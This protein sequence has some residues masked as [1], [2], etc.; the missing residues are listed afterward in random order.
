MTTYFASLQENH[1]GYAAIFTCIGVGFLSLRRIAKES[2][3][4]GYW[5]ASFFLNALGFLFWSGAVPMGRAA[6]YLLGELFHVAGFIFLVTG[7]YRFVGNEYRKWNVLAL[8]LW[9]AA[10]AASILA[11]RTHVDVAI[12]S[13]KALRAVIFISAGTM[14]LFQGDKKMT[15][16]RK[17]AGICLMLWGIY[18]LIFAFFWV[19][20]YLYFGFLVGFHVLAAFGMVA[21][22]MD[23]IRAR[24]EESERRVKKLEG[25]LPICAYCKKIRD[26]KDEWQTLEAYIEDRSK[27]EFSHGIC[28]DCF[29]KHL[30]D[31]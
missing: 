29:K 31:R 14:L 30:P 26:E 21:M 24:A 15:I 3:G 25:I 16:G 23:R 10:W 9:L 11:L 27:A 2:I 13:L 4:P 18:I 12:F 19:N 5:A 7:A 6:Y 28:P 8:A 1:L 20:E 22:V 17:E